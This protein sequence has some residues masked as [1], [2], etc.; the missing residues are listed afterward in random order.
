MII[1]KSKFYVY[2]YFI[3]LLNYLLIKYIIYKFIW[4]KYDTKIFILF[5]KKL[6]NHKYIN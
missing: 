2:K 1:Y 5:I 4:V 6:Y 3:F